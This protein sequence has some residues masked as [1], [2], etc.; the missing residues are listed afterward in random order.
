MERLLSFWNLHTRITKEAEQYLLRHG[1]LETYGSRMYFMHP[2]QRKP[3]WCIVLDGLACGY[4]V[5]ATG[6]RQIRWFAEPLQGFTGVRHLY[7]PRK[8]NHYIQFLAESRILKVPALKM[9][10]AKER[11]P[12]V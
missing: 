11:F 10:I 12:E 9:R 7:T 3:Y 4:I 5:D 2:H 1:S 8:S 6:E